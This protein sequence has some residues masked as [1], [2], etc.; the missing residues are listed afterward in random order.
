MEC[1]YLL[2]INNFSGS[3]RLLWIRVSLQSVMLCRYE[4]HF[5]SGISQSNFCI[6]HN[7]TESVII[8]RMISQFNLLWNT[9]NMSVKTYR[10]LLGIPRRSHNHSRNSRRQN[11]HTSHWSWTQTHPQSSDHISSPKRRH[12][13]WPTELCDVVIA[14]NISL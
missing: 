14:Y 10:L 13:H 4:C 12:H 3:A 2:R 9:W 5:V 7:T 11:W 8:C 1:F 6:F